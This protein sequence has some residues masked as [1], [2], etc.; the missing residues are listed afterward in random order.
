M[1]VLLSAADDPGPLNRAEYIKY[2]AAFFNKESLANTLF[3]QTVARYEAIKAA[4][5][6]A[7]AGEPPSCC[8]RCIPLY[9]FC[10]LLAVPVL[11]SLVGDLLCQ[12]GTRW[13]SRRKARC[14]PTCILCSLNG[15]IRA[16]LRGENSLWPARAEHAVLCRAAGSPPLVAWIGYRPSNPDWKKYDARPQG[17][18]EAVQLYFTDFRK[19]YTEVRAKQQQQI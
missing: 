16:H 4:A 6:K 7:A 2:M 19:A 15:C 12:L 3:N 11:R 10:L 13:G 17:W 1:R 9:H 18:A 14:S 8:H 5:A